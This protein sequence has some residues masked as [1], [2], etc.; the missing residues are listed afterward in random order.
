MEIIFY[1]ALSL[2]LC[3][4]FALLATP[5][6][7]RPAPGARRMLEVVRST[8]VDQR[9]IGDKERTEQALLAIARSLR[10]WLGF[11]DDT[12]L[13]QRFISAGLRAGN[14]TEVYFA[15]RLLCPLAGVVAGS[16]VHGN[17]V[18]ACLILA[19]VGY[20][21]PDLWLSKMVQ[22]R[23]RRIQRGIP[24]AI[25]LM[26]ICVDAGLGLDQA[27]L[28]VGQELA[29]SQPALSEEFLRVNLEQRA[30]KP[31]L[32]AWQ[33]MAARTLIPEFAALVNMLVQTDRFGTP[34]IRA[35]SRFADEMRLKRR[36][37]A[38]EAAAKTKIKI[39]F[40]LI[41]FIFPSVFIVL[42]GPAV[43]NMMKSFSAFK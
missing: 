5:L 20:A 35:L 19:F 39:L 25:D 2:T 16:L 22:R 10:A 21:L 17:P 36:Q 8:R 29:I 38:E 9:R 27:L 12:K 6:F 31:R 37:R 23:R 28:R 7:F 1:T 14:Q 43:L 34:I 33:T 40:P 4:L 42:L 11:A 26:V 13:K 41:L 3:S 30:G 32:E 18:V 15:C 24:D